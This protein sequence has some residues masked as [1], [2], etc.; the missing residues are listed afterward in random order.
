GN[1][2]TANTL[3]DSTGKYN[4]SNLSAGSYSITFSK[5]E[6]Y[7]FT[8]LHAGNTTLDSDASPVDGKTASINL[9]SSTSNLDID[10]GLYR[11]SFIGDFVWNDLN[12]NGIQDPGEPGVPNISLQLL[13][14]AQQIISSTLS[15]SEGA[16]VFSNLTPGVYSVVAILPETF[17]LT[18]R[19]GSM[20]EVNSDF[21]MI[22]GRIQTAEITIIS[23]TNNA[24]IDLGVKANLGAISGTIWSDVNGNGVMDVTEPLL[25]SSL[26]YVLNPAGDTLRTVISASDGTYLFNNVLPGQYRL[27][28]AAKADSLFTYFGLGAD[29]LFDSDVM[30][31]LSG[32]TGQ[33]TLEAG[34]PIVGINAGYVGYSSLGDFVWLDTNENGLQ[35]SLENGVNDIKVY[36][37]D[38]LGVLLDSTLTTMKPGSSSFGFYS[39]PKI[40]YGTYRIKFGLRTNFK[41][42]I[43][44]LAN[45]TINSD[46]TNLTE[47]L[48][49][50]LTLIPNQKRDDIDAGYV[51]M[52][53]TTGCISGV[54]WEDSNNSKVREDN[55]TKIAGIT[56]KLHTVDGAILATTNT[57]AGGHY[58]FCDLPFGSYYIST[59]SIPDKLF[60]L[61]SG[62]SLPFDSD[63][64]HQFGRGTTRVLN[65][66]PGDTLKDID[67][68]VASKVSIGDFVWDDLNNN[69]LQDA[70]EPGIAGISIS[71]V[72]EAGTIQST[73][74][75]TAQGNYSFTDVPV[76][77]YRLSFSGLA[78]YVFAM[79]DMTSTTLN[80]KPDAATGITA[81][82]DFGTIQNFSNID[83][84][85][86]K[87]ASIGQR[88]WLDLNG[89]GFFQEGEPG[90][91]DI[92][93]RLFT[94]S[95][96][97]KDSTKTTDLAGTTFVGEYQFVNVRPGSYYIKFDIPDGY[98]ISPS[99]VGDADHDSNI[100]DAN[101]PKTTDN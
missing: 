100:T 45:V 63:I 65:V 81:L 69:G 87:A 16:Y 51:L 47:G 53:S 4:F 9:G 96:V 80:S 99:G 75:S 76:G 55:E 25:V 1:A 101:G 92:Q 61:Y 3:T 67:L 7:F 82:L 84:G 37:L 54:V 70:G 8:L 58:I 73:T 26:V 74:Q 13:N 85:Y 50:W 36:L 35:D 88:V 21:S 52:A 41:F 62:V 30:D 22:N 18:D 77:K 93:I 86:V 98:L 39:F 59:D 95:G 44:T 14:S 12:V 10:A 31:S 94:T 91:E 17:V 79:N 33:L 90:I 24:H 48:T 64:T 83:A 89:N 49:Q 56:L 6:N 15:D 11:P 5:P 34:K 38:H 97:L 57:M 78:G 66:F 72:S 28:F 43:N 71:L 68:G 40:P 20:D 60:V 46:V 32:L 2:V 29:P 19:V 23:N 42:T 27:R